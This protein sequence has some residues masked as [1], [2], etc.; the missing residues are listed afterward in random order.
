[1]T[2]TAHGVATSRAVRVRD[3]LNDTTMNDAYD[4]AQHPV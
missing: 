4:I 1:M 3:L 2:N